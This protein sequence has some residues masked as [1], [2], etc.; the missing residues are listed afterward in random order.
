MKIARYLVLGLMAAMLAGPGNAGCSCKSTQGTV[1]ADLDLNA[2]P[3]NLPFGTVAIG[4]HKSLTVTLKHVGSSG[5]VDISGVSLE[6]LSD[7]FTFTPPEKTSLAVGEEVTITVT[8]TPVNATSSY[9]NLVIEHNVA[10]LGNETKIPVTANGQVG[11]IIINPNPVDFGQV[12]TGKD[13]MQDVDLINTGSDSVVLNAISL[14]LDGSADFTIEAINLPDSKVMPY[15]LAPGETIGLVLKYAPTGGGKDTSTLVIEGTTQGQYAAWS[16]DVLGEEMGPLLVASPGQLDFQ[17]VPL[18]TEKTLLLDVRNDGNANLV[19][20]KDGLSLWMN[21]D[22]MIV[23]KNP[24]TADVTIAPGA[25][26]DYTIGWTP[27]AVT[28]DDGKPIGQLMIASN[29]VSHSPMPIQVFGRPDAPI[30]VVMPDKVDMGFGAMMTPVT[31]PVTF[32]NQGTATLNV[33]S[34]SI[35]NPS[36]T[37]HGEEFQLVHSG[38]AAAVT[39]GAFDI[40]G[41]ASDVVYVKFTTKAPKE[42][43]GQTITATMRIVSNYMGHETIDVPITAQRSGAP[44]CNVAIVPNGVNFGAVAIGWPAEKPVNLVNIGTGNCTFLKAQ[45]N[46]CG[47]GLIGTG[48]S[49]PFTGGSSSIFTLKGAPTPNSPLTP[50]T[51]VAMTVRFNPPSS[52]SL[53]N[54]LNQYDALLGVQVKDDVLGTIIT[55]PKTAATYQANLIGSSGIAKISVL[56]GEVKFGVTTIG[57]FSKTYKVCIYNSGNAPLTVS[58]ISLKGCSPEFKVKNVP[59]LPMTVPNGAP[60]CIEAVY[61]PQDEGPDTCFLQIDAT[62]TSS[63]QV[64]VKLSGTG[65]KDSHQVDEFTQVTGQEV[66]ILFIIDD[67]G[68]MCDKQTKLNNAYTDFISSAAVWN[69]DYHI[70]VISVNVVDEKVLGR[71]NRGDNS[72]TPRFLTKTNGGSFSNLAMLGCDGGSDPQESAF[73]PIQNALSAPLATDT[74]LPCSSDGECANNANICPD[75]TKCAYTCQNGTCGGYNAGFLRDDA[76][77][78]FLALSDE[79]EQSPGGLPLYIDFLKNIKGWYNVDMMHFNAIVGITGV[80]ATPSSSSTGG[81]CV[82]SDGG[83]ADNGARYLEMVKETNGISDSICNDSYAAVMKK[84]GDVTFHPKVQFFLSR[85]A[86][87]ATVSVKVNDNACTVGWHYDSPSNSIIFDPKGTCMPGPGDKIRVEYDT[88][89]LTS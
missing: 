39:V 34:V 24:P 33:A 48:C 2:T 14:R 15:T 31:R 1:A 69:N 27:T 74:G 26:Y 62:D 54:V 17:A 82:G 64:M 36:D 37:T 42:S 38:G 46:D 85:L 23:V 35:V 60:K 40:A 21:S 52:S 8:Y 44:I 7:E 5:T 77:L 83:T 51:T 76:Q 63:P 18:N 88:L 13:L 9:G 19:I 72:K 3:S 66:D 22:P 87:P 49:A 47:S 89:C 57:C 32:S 28:V 73:E 55:L 11:D 12:D 61:A 53:F 41:A 84:I 67:S 78:E 71:L 10:S 79:E 80:P 65:T 20:P 16:F 58:D 59:K 50:G 45:I 30:L 70:G 68:S 75:P 29:D 81:D 86:D 6:F 43:N 4:D 25:S 56:P